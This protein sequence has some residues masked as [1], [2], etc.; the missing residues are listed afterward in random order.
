LGNNGA[1]ADNRDG[2]TAYLT[3][4][5]LG[6]KVTVFVDTGSDYTAIP[7]SAVEHARK[8]GSPL[9]VDELPEL[10]MLKLAIRGERD[11]Q[12]CSA[13]EMLM[14]P[15][16]ITTPSGPLCMRGVQQIIVEEE[17]DHTLIGRPVLDEIGFVTSQHLDYVRDKFHLHDFSNIG[18]DL[19]KMYKQPSGSLYEL[20]FKPADIPEFIEDFPDVLPLA[21]GNNKKKRE[22]IKPSVI[23]QDQCGVLRSEGDDGDH[24]VLQPNIKFA[25]LKEQSL[26]YGDITDDD[27]TDYH[28]VEVGQGSPE[29]MADAIESLVTGSEQAV[30][31]RDGVQSLRQLV[32]ECNDVFRI[33]LGADPPEHVKPIVIKLRDG[34]EPVRMSARKYAPPQLKF[35]RDKIRE[36]EELGLVYKYTRKEWASPLLILSKPGPD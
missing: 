4:E 16:T 10:I 28:D 18:E 14:S 7:R 35:M 20:L 36:L 30:M 21:K 25:S 9:K 3:V 12:K 33:K 15:V 2:K 8:R 1:T 34:A 32:T 6:V 27:T 22:K 5:N 26:F 13:T 23:D 17:M 24:D 29:E 19:L 31:S 11:K